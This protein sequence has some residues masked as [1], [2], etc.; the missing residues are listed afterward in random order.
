MGG[1][2]G[3][4]RSW[5]GVERGWGCEGCHWRCTAPASGGVFQEVQLKKGRTRQVWGVAVNRCPSAPQTSTEGRRR[6]P[7]ACPPLHRTTP[8]HIQT[9]STACPPLHYSSAGPRMPP[10]ASPNPPFRR[11]SHPSSWQA[12]GWSPPPLQAGQGG[13]QHQQVS[14]P[15]AI[16][17]A[18]GGTAGGHAG[19]QA[20][21]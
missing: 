18:A 6:Q 16:T 19:A 8:S 20:A 17:P 10:P 7:H 15:A 5:G 9:A 12:S 13:K 4:G 3:R 21:Q 2:G 11:T 14:V 1:W